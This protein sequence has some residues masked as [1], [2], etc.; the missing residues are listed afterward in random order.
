MST[1]GILMLAVVWTAGFGLTV[2][3][4]DFIC[5]H[6]LHNPIVERPRI[7]TFVMWP[8]AAV[9]ILVWL[10]AHLVLKIRRPSR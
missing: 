6:V 7:G 2:I 9:F 8:V 10:A 5:E 1:T 3:V 4:G